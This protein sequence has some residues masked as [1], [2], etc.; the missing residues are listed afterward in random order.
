MSRE[1]KSFLIKRNNSF[2]DLK[3]TNSKQKGYF[4]ITV[5]NNNRKP[6]SHELIENDL[7]YVAETNGGIYAKGLVTKSC[8]VDILH[9]IEEALDYS[10]FDKDDSYW[11]GKIREFRRKLANDSN[12]KLKCHR[13]FINQKIL[14]KT[15]PYNGPLLDYVKQGYATIFITLKNRDIEYLNS[16]NIYN[17]RKIDKLSDNIPSDLRLR[18]WSFFNVNSSIGHIVDIDHFVPK[19][20]GGPG[21]LIENLVPI[22][23][24]LNRYKSDSIPRS[25]FEL[26]ITDSFISSFDSY[27]KDILLVLK[28]SSKFISKYESPKSLSLAKE[29]NSEIRKW[30]DFKKIKKFYLE[31][32][33]SFNPEYVSLISEIE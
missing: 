6:L 23:F 9:T 19:N 25:F 22:G 33:K 29:L 30:S 10:K 28:N 21:N 27:K 26:A 7:I 5:T 12:Y 31:V 2:R 15:I 20:A 16:P 13:Y 3:K 17:L 14:P 11:I 4:E 1:Q 18:I 24:S 8:K 32:N